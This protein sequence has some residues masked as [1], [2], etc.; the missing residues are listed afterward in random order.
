MANWGVGL[1]GFA[2]GLADGIGLG[3]KMQKAQKQAAKDKA[4]GQVTTD[5]KAAFDADVAAGKAQPQD[6]NDRWSKSLSTLSQTY[7][8]HGDF[9]SAKA[10]QEW[11]ESEDTRRGV[12]SFRKI[13]LATQ[14]GDLDGAMTALNEMGGNKTY[15]PPGYALAGSEKVNGEDG[16]PA[17]YAVTVKGPGGQM[18]RQPIRSAEEIQQLAVTH[19]FPEKMAQANIDAIN[20]TRK[21][22]GTLGLYKDKL[23]ADREHAAME[24]EMG[25]TGTATYSPLV[26][27]IARRNAGIPDTDKSPYHV[28]STGELKAVSGGRAAPAPVVTDIYDP[29]T[30]REQKAVVDPTTGAVTPLGGTKAPPVRRPVPVSIQN[31]E[32]EDLH[33]VQNV[34]SINGLLGR[35]KEQIEGGTL[36]LG[37]M[38]NFISGAR[39]WAGNSSPETRNFASFKAGLEKLRNESLRL[40]KGVQTEGDA[41]RAWN[42]L[43]ANINDPEV[44]KQRIEE[45]VRLNGEAAEFRGNL[46]QQ[47]RQDNNL[48]PLDIDRLIV[49]P[50]AD[51]APSGNGAGAERAAPP[52]AR[53]NQGQVPQGTPQQRAMAEAPMPIVSTPEDAMRLP[54]GTR[55]RTP[56]GREKVRP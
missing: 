51:A 17:G 4:I 42:E 25:L 37:P 52:A 24:K 19:L 8:Q 34:T 48:D 30:G 35:F 23:S 15:L 2:D 33:G 40:N 41:V 21:N 6:W 39:N 12:E 31:A 32:A 9:E 7:A 20:E 56:D 55:F 36:E 14:A 27:P 29:A 50:R 43:I 49:A 10:A 47:R 3:E 18:F 16:K 45:I 44:V 54:P 11:G 53:K 5:T 38:A 26:D 28:S 46:I 1:G 22:R 13:M